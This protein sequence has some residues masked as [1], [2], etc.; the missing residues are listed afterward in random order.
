MT[1]SITLR[2]RRSSA[3][4]D[5]RTDPVDIRLAGAPDAEATLAA[6][7]L[8]YA[9]LCKW[10]FD[11]DVAAVYILRSFRAWRAAQGQGCEATVHDVRLTLTRITDPRNPFNAVY[12]RISGQGPFWICLDPSY[13]PLRAR[14]ALV[15]EALHIVERVTHKSMSEPEVH[16]AASVIVGEVLPQLESLNVYP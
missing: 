15:H 8:A 16:G 11:A 7:I 5:L 3:T 4:L 10:R 12:G 2:A 14:V 13:G 1:R 6:A 9:Y